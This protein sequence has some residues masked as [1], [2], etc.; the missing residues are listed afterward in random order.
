M[1]ILSYRA[2]SGWLQYSPVTIGWRQ[3]VLLSRSYSTYFKKKSILL[4]LLKNIHF[5][6]SMRMIVTVLRVDGK[7]MFL[8]WIMDQGLWLLLYS[9]YMHAT[10]IYNKNT[11]NLWAVHSISINLGF[12]LSEEVTLESIDFFHIWKDC[13]NLFTIKEGTVVTASLEKALKHNHN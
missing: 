4:I 8:R 9:M 2:A 3:Y 5:I 13:F 6:N 7:F 1:V 11:A 12:K 10:Y